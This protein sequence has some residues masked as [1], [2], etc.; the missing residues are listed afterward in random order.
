MPRKF[1]V[2]YLFIMILLMTSA[3]TSKPISQSEKGLVKETKAVNELDQQTLPTQ[4]MVSQDDAPEITETVVPTDTP[5]EKAKDMITIQIVFDNYY[6]GSGMNTRWGFS[7]FISY[8]D[9][10]VLFDTGDNGNV[11]LNNMSVMGI[12]PS[13]VQNVVLSHQHGDHTNGLRAILSSGAEPKLYLLPSF[14]SSFKSAY[15]DEVE[16]IEVSPG[17]Q[18]TDRI[19]S[20]GEISGSV[21][22]Q[23][24][25]IDTTEGLV[26]ITGCAHP[27]V[28]T[29]VEAA[30]EVLDKEV[31]LVLGGFHLGGASEYQINEI[32][33]NL[34]E[35]GVHHIGPCHCTGDNAINQFKEAFGEKYIKVGAGAVIEIE[36]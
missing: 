26:V 3:C 35:L 7:A 23:A 6:F 18:I 24:V 17:E 36:L 2:F 11:L 5:E 21:H 16:V 13:Q 34:S 29:M 32:I 20:T 14:T 30:K 4:E 10:N 25:L 28:V 12:E 31:Y 19:F 8:Q 15:Q 9:K 1:F 22:E 27:G 33:D